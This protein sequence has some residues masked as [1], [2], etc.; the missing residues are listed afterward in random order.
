MQAACATA[1]VLGALVE[2]CL[3]NRWRKPGPKTVRRAGGLTRLRRPGGE[4]PS[5]RVLSAEL[6]LNPANAWLPTIAAL[7]VFYVAWVG[8][9]ALGSVPRA[10]FW[11][12]WAIFIVFA[13]MNRSAYG[14]HSP[15][16]RA[17]LPRGR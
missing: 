3:Y 1:F 6:G 13:L 15:A 11:V 2:P 16:P 17:T 14:H 8:P 4:I 7:S 9:N 12:V 10:V 5:T